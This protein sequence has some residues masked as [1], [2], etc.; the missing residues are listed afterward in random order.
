L[1]HAAKLVQVEHNG[2]RKIVFLANFETPPD[3]DRRSTVM[4]YYELD[5]TFQDFNDLNKKKQ[6]RRQWQGCFLMRC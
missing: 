5:T 4:F 6:P 3:F 1:N 2:K